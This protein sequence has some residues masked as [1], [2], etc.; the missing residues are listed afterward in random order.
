MANVATHLIAAAVLSTGPAWADPTDYC[1]LATRLNGIV[2]AE[3]GYDVGQECPRIGFS[4]PLTTGVPRSQAG[5]YLPET[6]EIEL[7]P[8]LDLSSAYGQSYLLHEL[9]HAAQYRAGRQEQV[10]CP[11]KLEAE[12]SLVQAAFLHDQ[13]LGQ[14]A[15]LI[16]ALAVQLGQCGQMDY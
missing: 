11:A 9:V 8:D 3:T 16:E 13:G 4:I 14:E 5:A 10:P 12:A 7:A 1:G 6:G 2:A 15:V